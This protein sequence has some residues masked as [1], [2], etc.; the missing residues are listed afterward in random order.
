MRKR[1]VKNKGL[2]N[3]RLS[4]Y[5]KGNKIIDILSK[6]E[7]TWLLVP[8]IFYAIGYFIHNTYL[9]NYATFD[10]EIIQ[11][12]Y[13]YIGS[14]FSF[15]ITLFV[16]FLLIGI[17]FEGEKTVPTFLKITTWSIRLPLILV[18]IHLILYPVEVRTHNIL[19]IVEGNIFLI[20]LFAFTA[21]TLILYS[22]WF[23]L[24]SSMY[25]LS[26]PRVDRIIR[27]FFAFSIIPISITMYL[28][29]HQDNYFAEIISFITTPLF[30]LFIFMPILFYIGETKYISK[31]NILNNVISSLLISFLLFFFMISYAK[32]IYPNIPSS[33]GG[34]EPTFAII[35]TDTDTIRCELLNEN[36]EWLLI[37]SKESRV[38]ERVRV[39]SIKHIAISVDP[40]YEPVKYQNNTKSRSTNE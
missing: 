3:T 25:L 16:F 30:L 5:R 2:R 23:A 31:S 7:K 12:K 24:N 36:S 28:Y 8:F 15:Y 18:I 1:I 4:S 9:S 40:I 11:S 34:A 17:G 13:I 6:F 29:Y 27:I 20:I 19:S 37:N 21:I 10:F 22:T 33:F 38:Y 26:K 39:E 32:N 14:L 35:Y